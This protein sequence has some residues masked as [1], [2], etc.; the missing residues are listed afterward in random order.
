MLISAVAIIFVG[1]FSTGILA[2]DRLET[3]RDGLLSQALINEKINSKSS[4]VSYHV[5]N[6]FLK[7]VDKGRRG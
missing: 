4:T 6:S 5:S 3:T 7:N 2:S 1:L